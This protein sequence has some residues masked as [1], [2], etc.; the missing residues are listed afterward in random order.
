M[1]ES[2]IMNGWI[3]KAHSTAA[4]GRR[5]AATYDIARRHRDRERETRDSQRQASAGVYLFYSLDLDGDGG[6]V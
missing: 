1:Q 2:Y 4:G 6:R 3:Y 5:A